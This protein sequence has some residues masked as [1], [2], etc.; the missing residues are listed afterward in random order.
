M[1]VEGE[2][3]HMKQEE[4]PVAAASPSQRVSENEYV[5][6]H[7]QN[8][9]AHF[10]SLFLNYSFVTI[11]SSP[12]VL[13][14]GRGTHDSVLLR[15]RHIPALS[16]DDE[17]LQKYRY[18]GERSA[19]PAPQARPMHFLSTYRYLKT[20]HTAGPDRRLPSTTAGWHK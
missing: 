12:Q 18:Q 8:M 10:Q 15:N 7:S 4:A 11:P 6:V 20:T 16:D 19:Q 9:S 5:Y 13:R 17:A 1:L 3:S 2:Y 14:H